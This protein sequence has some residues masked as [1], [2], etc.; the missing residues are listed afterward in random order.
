MSMAETGTRQEEA[1][2]GLGLRVGLLPTLRDV[3]LIGDARAVA[4]AHPES[5]FAAALDQVEAELCGR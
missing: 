1:L 2:H 4:A 5:A 3:D